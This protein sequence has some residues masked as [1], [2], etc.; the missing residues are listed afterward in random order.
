MERAAAADSG[1]YDIFA[2]GINVDQAVHVAEVG[3]R[4]HVSLAESDVVIL[5]DRIKQGSEETVRLGIG[6]VD[7]NSRIQV[8]TTCTIY[9]QNGPSC[10]YI[11]FD[12]MFLSYRWPQ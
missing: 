6:C 3:R 9:K 12:I 2:L 5:D 11:S 4:M 8:L 7:T 10:S 1:G